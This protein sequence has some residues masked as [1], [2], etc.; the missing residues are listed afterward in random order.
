MDMMKTPALLITIFKVLGLSFFIAWGII[1]LIAAIGGTDWETIWGITKVILILC[2]IFIPITFL[3]YLI[4]SAQ[5]GRKYVVLFEM[6]EQGVL[7]RQLR[8]NVKRD[9]AIAWLTVLAGV[10]AGNWG[11][12]S[13]G[14]VSAT[15]DSLYSEFSKVRSVK[16]KRKWNTIKVNE[17]LT[18]NQVYAEKQ[19]FDFVYQYILAHCTRLQS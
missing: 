2:A 11:A 14:F 16:P 9:K 3:A 8:K 1:I 12:A 15:H 4:V 6:D 7:H 17:L 18:K 5:N 19:D 13:A 10:A